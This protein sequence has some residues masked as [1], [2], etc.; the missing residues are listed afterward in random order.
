MICC[1]TGHRPEGFPFLRGEGSFLYEEYKKQLSQEIAMLIDAG[2]DYFV[3]GMA[4]GAD[5]DFASA[6]VDFRDDLKMD[7]ILEGALPYPIH[8]CKM[9]QERRDALEKCDRK[10]TVSAHYFRGCMQKRNCY[11][12]DK[13]E[14]VLAIW[15]GKEQGGTWNTIRYARAKGKPIRYIVL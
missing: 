4:E 13:S 8:P 6:V 2:Y 1:V 3:S 5:T 10:K 11:M 14:L 15:N 7:I 12:V 9:S